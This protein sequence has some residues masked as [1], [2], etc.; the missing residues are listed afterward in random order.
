M[1]MIVEGTTERRLFTTGMHA[2]ES[3]FG[4]CY[5]PVHFPFVQENAIILT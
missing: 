1:R 5:N 4:N 2:D 3:T